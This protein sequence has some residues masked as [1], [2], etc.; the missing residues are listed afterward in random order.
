M[1]GWLTDYRDSGPGAPRVITGPDGEHGR[2]LV[3]VR[4]LSA[5]MGTHGGPGGRTVW[6]QIDWDSHER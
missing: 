5:R 1:T 3:L 4:G 2:G 6:A